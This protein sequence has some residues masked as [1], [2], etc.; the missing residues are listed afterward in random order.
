M[1]ISATTSQAVAQFQ[2]NFANITDSISSVIVGN[3]DI[4]EGVLIAFFAQGHVLLEGLPGLGKTLLVETLKQV[5]DLEHNRIQCTPDLMPADI[6][7]TNVLLQSNSGPPVVNFA[8]GPIFANLVLADE[9]NRATPRTQ[10]ALL[11]AMQEREVTAGG[12]THPLPHPFMVI[13]TQNPIEMEGTYPLPEAQLDRFFFKLIV[14]YPNLQELIEIALRTTTTQSIAIDHRLSKK[15][16]GEMIDFVRKVY[17]ADYLLKYVAQLVLATHPQSKQATPL[18]RKYVQYGASP[19][20]MQAII[21][22]A[23]VRALLANRV[24]VAREDILETLVP[25]LQHRILINFSG[26]AEGVR[27][28]AIIQQLTEKITSTD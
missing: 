16:I 23:K 8:Q 2:S 6:L 11:Q 24:H 27:P 1:E 19:R 20:G 5:L 3:R 22:G 13:A 15:I 7:G 14:S 17:I 26:E 10:S 25:A 12:T 28:H 21:L 9:I 18:V 4:I